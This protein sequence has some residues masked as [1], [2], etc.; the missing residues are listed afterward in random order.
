MSKVKR[1]PLGE[2]GT[3]Q[4]GGN[5]K[6]SDFIED[7]YPCIHYGQIHTKFGASTSSHITCIPEAIAAKCPKATKGDLVIAITSEDVA[8]SCKCT[9]WLGDYDVALG[10]HIARFRHTLNP[11]YVSYFFQSP[12]FHKE[13][14][15]YT[16]G[17]KVT[18]IKPSDIAKITIPVVDEHKQQ[19][20]V[21]YLDSAFLKINQMQ[22][23]A[24]EAY[25]K[26]KNLFSCK[27]AELLS[28]S[29]D[30]KESTLGQI[31]T[32]AGN[33][34]LSVSSK[35]FDGIRYLRITDITEWGDLNENLVSADIQDET[36]QVP[37]I[38][39]DILFA[40]TGATVGKTLLYKEHFG[41]CLFA[42]YLIRYRLNTHIMLPKFLFYITHSSKYY[43]WVADNQKVAAQPNIS[44]KTYNS[45][46]LKFPSID[47]QDCII[48]ELDTIFEKV[49][50]LKYNLDAITEKCNSLK[51]AILKETFE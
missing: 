11:K 24:I 38:E 5:F 23:N 9:T 12:T 31:S 14:S 19:E 32:I 1:I 42:G 48:K 34:G 44:A 41:E 40:R 49:K 26:A 37:L 7:G 46:T 35:P 17:F 45:L 13:K 2:V 30:W 4:R 18:E 21:N 25:E 16:R 43:K 36:R 27:L 3:F 39:G 22:E 28:P 10:G 51:Q 50:T 15:Q 29:N 8:G 20:I 33:Y 6:K 47:R